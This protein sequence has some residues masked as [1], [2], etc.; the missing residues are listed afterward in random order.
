MESGWERRNRQAAVAKNGFTRSTRFRYG[1]F[2][3]AYGIAWFLG[4][5]LMG[6]LYDVS[7]A[8]LIA[9]SMGSQ[10]IALWI[11]FTIRHA[12]PVGRS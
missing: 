9:F 1:L 8:G 5:A 12:W 7:I 10:I 3:P 4:S 11:L 2:N 6:V